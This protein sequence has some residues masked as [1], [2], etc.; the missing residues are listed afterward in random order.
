MMRSARA[1]RDWW[2]HHFDQAYW[3]LHH[4]LFPE[5]QSRREVAG[6]IE[7]LGQPV[8]VRVLDAPC[9]WGR[10]TV[11][12]AEAGYDVTGADLSPDLLAQ[13]PP[14]MPP[15]AAAD[16]RA[17]PFADATFD[18]VLNVFTSL[19]LF[20]DDA[21]DVRALSE[22]RR[23]LVHGGVFLLES[24]HRD[25]VMA[26][27]AERDAWTLPDGTEVRARRRFD[28]LTGVC[29]E[30]IRWRRGSERGEKLHALRLRTATEIDVLLKAAGFA[31]IAYHGDWDGSPF[32]HRAERL[33][34]LARNGR[35]P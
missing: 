21:E 7:L 19:G 12:L 17:L 8:G 6:M 28:P 27:Y 29:H 35:H 3:R 9:G 34:A 14:G 18:V 5:A 33:I 13:A 23:V 22:A 26:N 30:R 16:I 25:D 2:R 31:E 1:P 10:H 20:L 32:H 4:P 24:M 11:L 15:A